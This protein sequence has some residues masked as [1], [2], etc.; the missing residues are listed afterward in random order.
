M[1][2]NTFKWCVPGAIAAADSVKDNLKSTLQ[3][4]KPQVSSNYSTWG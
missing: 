1:T 3:I 2:D 4:Q